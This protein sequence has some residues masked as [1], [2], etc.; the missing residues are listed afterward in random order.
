MNT[1][2]I[3]DISLFLGALTLGLFVL[4]DGLMIMSGE[5]GVY[6]VIPNPDNSHMF[7]LLGVDAVDNQTTDVAPI[8]KTTMYF[9]GTCAQQERTIAI[10]PTLVS[11]MGKT[12]AF[13]ARSQHLLDCSI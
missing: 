3:K 8:T 5:Y 7:D 6:R 12:F 13:N 10:N 11:I 4:K 2:K 1:Q 9:T